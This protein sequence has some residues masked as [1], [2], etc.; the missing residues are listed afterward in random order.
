MTDATLGSTVSQTG[1]RAKTET[2][3]LRLDPKIRFTLEFLARVRGQSITSVV[4]HAIRETATSNG[5]GPRYDDRGNETLQKT[6]SDFWDPSEGIRALN[7]LAND[8][9]P[10]TF[11][12]DR[13]RQFTLSHWQFFYTNQEGLTPRRAYVDILWP[14]I[15]EYLHIWEETKAENYWAAGEAMMGAIRAAR[16]APPTNWP[17]VPNAKPKRP[18]VVDELDDDIPF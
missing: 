1:R 5:I 7:L 2:L 9:Y 11:D 8:N 4:E 16:V 10:T 13:L 15:Q 12:E 6:W 14:R 17:P 3:S 18:S